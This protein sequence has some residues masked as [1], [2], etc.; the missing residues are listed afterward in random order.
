[1]RTSRFL[2]GTAVFHT[3]LAALVLV[4]ARYRDRS[5]GRW[6]ALTL[7]FGIGGVAGYALAER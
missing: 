2:L 5:A 3:V 4:H 1:M 7:A 6:V